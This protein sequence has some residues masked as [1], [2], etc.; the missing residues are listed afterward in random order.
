MIL[1][2][3]D[4]GFGITGYGIIEARD[5]QNPRLVEAGIIKSKKEKTFSER[6]GEIH[7]QIEELLGE[8]KPSCV[9]VEDIYSAGAFPRSAILIGHVRG[10][11]LL[12]AAQNGIPVF[13]YYP[14][15]VKKALLGNG[16]ATKAQVQRMVQTSLGLDQPI[17]PDD[18]S[19]ALAIA[20]C[21]ANHLRYSSGVLAGIK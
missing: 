14:L 10:I 11:V 15:Q 5:R 13:S 4:P 8:F 21:H 16:N 19:D 2:G 1:L 7:E 6:L 20:L 18:C 9:A 17:H 12:C 3:I